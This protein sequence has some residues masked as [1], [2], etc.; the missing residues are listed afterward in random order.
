[1]IDI[2]LF[3]LGMVLLPHERVP[4]HIFEERY[5]ELVQECLD[6]EQPFGLLLADEDDYAD[7]GTLAEIAEVTR[8]F[9]DGRLNIVIEGLGRFRVVEHTEGRPFGTARVEEIGDAEAQPSNEETDALMAAF[10]KLAEAADAEAPT[11]STA[12]PDLGFRLAALVELENTPRQELL[13]LDSER[14]RTE[15]LTRLFSELARNITRQREIRGRAE[16]NGRVEA[17]D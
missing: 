7:V 8:R 10:A 2:G 11:V 9:P 13:E 4:L 12:E 3:P 6:E 5:K 1:M 17:R 14:A 15:Y 16:S